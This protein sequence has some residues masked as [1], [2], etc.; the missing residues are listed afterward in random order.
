MKSHGRVLEKYFRGALC[1]TQTMN[2]RVI[3]LLKHR[4]CLVRLHYSQ[5]EW[6]MN[7][8][9][10]LTI[11]KLRDTGR[12]HNFVTW[13]KMEMWRSWFK[14]NYKLQNSD[15][16][17]LN[18]AWGLSKN[19]RVLK[20]CTGLMTM[21]MYLLW[22]VLSLRAHYTSWKTSGINS[23]KIKENMQILIKSHKERLKELGTFSKQEMISACH[24]QQ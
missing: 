11:L 9:Y 6:E 18:E 20:D 16:K 3:W 2:W 17:A 8:L 4:W 12:L 1:C 13:C 23:E 10:H 19:M 21:K 14:N 22:L 5:R 24:C 15:S 7:C